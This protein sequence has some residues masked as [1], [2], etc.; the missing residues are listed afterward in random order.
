[1][2]ANALPATELD[3]LTQVIGPDEPPLSEELSRSLLAMRF[4]D[5]AEANIRSLL[6]K[7]NR[8]QL[9]TAEREALDRYLRVGQFI[10]LLQAQ[11]RIRLQQ[12]A[13]T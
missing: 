11:A 12:S 6:E 9:S 5:E 7:N 3:V 8:G 10:D 2:I 4:T 1:M 13:G